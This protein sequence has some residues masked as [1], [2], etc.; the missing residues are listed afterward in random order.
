[1][2][3]IKTQD[4]GPWAWTYDSI[5]EIEQDCEKPERFDPSTAAE[6]KSLC[7]KMRVALRKAAKKM[8]QAPKL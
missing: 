8:T 7:S 5:R 1:M 4:P 2:K 6:L 3:Q